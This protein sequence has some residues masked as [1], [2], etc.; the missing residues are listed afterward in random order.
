[1]RN[2]L[3]ILSFMAVVSFV[4]SCGDYPC[5][6]ASLN[7]RL[8]GFSDAETDTIIL[9]R[10]Q[11]K[12]MIV[13]DSVVFDPSNGI[14]FARFADTLIMAAYPGNALLESNYDYQLFFPG[15]AR[16]IHVTEITEKQSDG[17]SAGPF[18]SKKEGCV[19]EISSCKVDGL[20]GGFF[21]SNGIYLKK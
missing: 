1:M 3:L 8:I 2:R 11:K 20:P 6:K 21:F 15:A 19:N 12:S 14:S 17:A 4:M 13:K 10:M 16:T 9:R 18:N 7:Y 5:S